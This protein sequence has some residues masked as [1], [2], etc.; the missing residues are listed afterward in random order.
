VTVPVFV[1]A[2]AFPPIPLERTSETGLSHVDGLVSIR[3]LT[4]RVLDAP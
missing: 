1:K 3:I 2:D 4:V